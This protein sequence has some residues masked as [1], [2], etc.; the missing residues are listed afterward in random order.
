MLYRILLFAAKKLTQGSSL[1][2]LQEKK[3]FLRSAFFMARWKGQRNH[4]RTVFLLFQ[5][6]IS[7]HINM[8][9]NVTDIAFTCIF[10]MVEKV[11]FQQRPV[12]IIFVTCS[13]S[14]TYLLQFCRLRLKVFGYYRITFQYANTLL[15]QFD[16]FYTSILTNNRFHVLLLMRSPFLK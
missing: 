6:F 16:S 9:H 13:I 12:Q 4:I 8:H 5:Q 1:T 7:E 14:M 11:M 3:H 15:R 2:F 10:G